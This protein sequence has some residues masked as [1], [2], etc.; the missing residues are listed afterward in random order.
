[1]FWDVLHHY[2]YPYLPCIDSLHSR[3]LGCVNHRNPGLARNV[4]QDR[5]SPVAGLTTLRM[6]Q[7]EVQ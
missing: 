1:M 3:K 5:G 2:H 7:Q 4:Q 6:L